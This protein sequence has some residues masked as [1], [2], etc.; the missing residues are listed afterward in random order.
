[1]SADRITRIRI[2]G[3]RAIREADL[4]LDGL[5][6]LIGDNGT[7]KSSILTALEILRGASSPKTFVPDIIEGAHGGLT[8]LLRRGANELRVAATIEGAGPKLEYSVAVGFVGTSTQVLEER[9]Q[10]YASNDAAPL[11]ALLG[12]GGATMLFDPPGPERLFDNPVDG[13]HTPPTV[14]PVG[15]AQLGLRALG[16]RAPAP[17]QRVAAALENIEVHVPFETRPL[18]QVEE[19]GVQATPRRPVVTEDTRALSRYGLNLANAY[20]ALRNMD[21]DVW[22]RVL[23]RARLGLGQDVRNFRLPPSGRGRIELEIVFGSIPADGVPVEMLSEGQLSY[24]AFLAL[25][26]LHTER[27]LLAFDEPEL[28]LHPTLLA[29]VV[30]MLE[31]L[32]KRSPVILATHS[33]QL[34]DALSTP[35]ASVVLCAL[36][37]Q[38]AMTMTRP[39][40]EKLATW[41]EDYRGLGSIRA[42]GY[43]AH[44]FAKDSS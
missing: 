33:D 8:S 26:E 4:E 28:H 19:L 40:A 24:L 1:M 36:D 2:E 14:V 12:R 34:L 21:P 7:G 13:V 35:A 27:S 3:L 20:Q 39:D 43:T 17:L 11:C 29:R 10:V 31:G 42:E 18:W 22:N 15:Y 41:L 32:A 44:V 16:V 25:V 6:V 5:T 37:E 23:E 9:L 30:G 38:R